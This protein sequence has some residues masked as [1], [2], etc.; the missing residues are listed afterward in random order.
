MDQENG[1]QLKNKIED[2]RKQLE[3]LIDNGEFN[4]KEALELSK[5]MDLLIVRYH[6][7]LKLQ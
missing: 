1:N 6:D 7:L 5:E 3:L 4:R 2:L